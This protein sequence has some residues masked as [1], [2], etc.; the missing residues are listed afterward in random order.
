MLD[1][2]NT[3]VE[4]IRK[5]QHPKV[6]PLLGWNKVGGAPCLVYTLMEVG[7]LQDRPE[8]KLSAAVPHGQG[9]WCGAW[10]S[11]TLHVVWLTC[12]L[13]YPPL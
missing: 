2:M 6:V 7:S 8:G 5:V 13:K 9:E 4:V 1:Q 10:C 11:P 12:I 3:E